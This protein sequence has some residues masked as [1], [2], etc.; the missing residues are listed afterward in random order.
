[1]DQAQHK[2]EPL[3]VGTALFA[4]LWTVARAAIQSITID[5]ADTYLAYV[6]TPTPSH[7]LPSS[8]NHVLNSMLM[9]LTS[10]IFGVSNLTLRLPA[11]L[12]A[13]LY[14]GAVYILVRLM[15]RSRILGWAVFVC[16]VFNPMVMDYLSA[17]RGYSLAL[18][19]LMLSIAVAAR[20]K[21][22]G[23]DPRQ[24]CVAV[25]LLMGLSFCANFSFALVDAVT[26]AGIAWWLVPAKGTV[27]DYARIGAASILPGATVSLYLTA[28]ILA[29]WVR[30][31]LRWGATTFKWSMQSISEQC[32]YKLSPYLMDR[33]IYDFVIRHRHLLLPLLAL[34]CLWRL[35]MW[36]AERQRPVDGDTGW[37]VRLGL[38]AAAGAVLTLALHGL[39]VWTV[40]MLWPRGRTGLFVPPL[41]ILAVGALAA[42]P[43]ASKMSRASQRTIT[44]LLLATGCYFLLCLRLTWFTE[45]YW[46]ANSDRVYQVVA[47]YNHAYGV[48]TIGTNWRYVAVLNYY[49]TISGQES[50]EPI[51]LERP[52]PPGRSLYVL[53]PADDRDF[54]AKEGLK[55]VYHDVL[56]DAQ[57]A[58]RPE[59]ESAH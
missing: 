20:A 44:A 52:I 11:L 9:R 15:T 31:D 43:C 47:R 57:V 34:A 28:S 35:A 14:V 2:Q 25:S 22:R 55:V 10:T 45:W 58:I 39:L 16:M 23:S 30:N 24:T 59:L 1:L 4:L 49:R 26:L 12:G 51:E 38:L 29:H 50:L 56:S 36:I 13:V 32:F 18:G 27:R 53:F 37:L 17:A 8:N 6:G 7:W 33:P 46:N 41:C 40:H 19:L 54:L 21:A 3:L 48:R 42:L 5:E